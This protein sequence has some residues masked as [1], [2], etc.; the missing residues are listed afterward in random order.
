MT[1]YTKYFIPSGT[2]PQKLAEAACSQLMPLKD[3]VF[4][5]TSD[6][7]I[8]FTRHQTIAECLDADFFFADSYSSWQRGTNENTNGLVRQ[9]FPRKTDFSLLSDSDIH[10][11]NDRLNSRPRKVLAFKTPNEVFNNRFVALIT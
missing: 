1:I 10:F 3:K 7:G 2:S 11:V 8:E 5:I 9:Y 4:T 6:N